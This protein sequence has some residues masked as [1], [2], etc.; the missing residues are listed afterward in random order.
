VI[1]TLGRLLAVTTEL[2]LVSAVYLMGFLVSN[3]AFFGAVYYMTRLSRLVL[4]N[5][6]SAFTSAALLAFYPAGVFLSA[7]YSDSLF[8]LLTSASLFYLLKN[9]FGKTAALGFLSSLTRPVGIVLL[10]PVVFKL[11][12]E[13]SW[14]KAAPILGIVL[15]FLSFVIY[16][17]LVAGTP[18]A[19]SL[20]EHAYWSLTFNPYDRFNADVRAILA[21]PIMLPFLGLSF[22]GVVAFVQ[23]VR[24]GDETV[25]GLYTICL[26]ATYL[27]SP[28]DSFP[29]YSITLLPT[30][31]SL[32]RWSEHFAPRVLIWSLFLTLLAVGT[33]LFANWYRFF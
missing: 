30:Y 10:V 22:G 32:S 1:G 15:G 8:L 24:S 6:R 28:L 16:G 27:V 13:P 19:T 26:L 11:L 18:F 14:R 5:S 29:R 21:N 25:I 2:R 31:W 7:V 3:A 4:G 23:R 9:D 12:R 33:G 20:A 17:Q